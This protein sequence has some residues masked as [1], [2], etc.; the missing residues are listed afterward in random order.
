MDTTTKN[1]QRTKDVNQS[2]KICFKTLEHVYSFRWL[3][4]IS[5]PERSFLLLCSV[6][7]ID[8]NNA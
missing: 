7:I 1:A 2:R 5:K 8:L 6:V 3:K 4:T